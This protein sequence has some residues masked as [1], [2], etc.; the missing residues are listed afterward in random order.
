MV[1]CPDCGGPAGVYAE[2]NYWHGLAACLDSKIRPD[3]SIPCGRVFTLPA[4]G[5]SVTVTG[6]EEVEAPVGTGEDFVRIE[7]CL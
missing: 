7:R 5:A 6:A 1:R 3:G 4:D 2:G